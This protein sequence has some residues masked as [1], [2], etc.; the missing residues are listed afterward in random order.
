MRSISNSLRPRTTPTNAFTLIELLVVIGII[1]ILAAM[2]MPSLVR[3][4]QQAN[5]IK[6]VNHLRQ[7]GM[8]A[9][10]YADEHDGEFPPRAGL[11]EN[12]MVRL[13]PDHANSNVLQCASDRFYSKRS[14]IINAF[15][16]YF[17]EQL[18]PEAYENYKRWRHPAGMREEA[19][20]RPDATIIFGEKAS[21]S[22][23][24]HM[25]FYQGLGNDMEEV[26]QNRH[27]SGGVQGRGGSNFTFVDGH[28]EMLVRGRSIEPEN[29]W[30][31]SAKWR[32]L[33]PATP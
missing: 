8:A 3:A 25:D 13:Y 22:Y 26:E 10:M 16:D 7:L 33:P 15:N 24:I 14:Y 18:S 23:H 31:V 5:R 32:S 21:D 2:L 30:A 17:E 20:P 6:C 11:T 4:K 1:A 12:W 9:K 29:L 27:G 28:V 19:G